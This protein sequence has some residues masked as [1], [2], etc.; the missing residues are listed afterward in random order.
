MQ[1]RITIRAN[2]A[3]RVIQVQL[4]FYRHNNFGDFMNFQHTRM[5]EGM[6]LNVNFNLLL[7]RKAQLVNIGRQ[8][9]CPPTHEEV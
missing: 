3:F 8:S 4:A 5:R 6:K 7:R 2:I 9:M 1:K